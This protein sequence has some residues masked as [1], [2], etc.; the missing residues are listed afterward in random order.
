MAL[1]LSSSQSSTFEPF[2]KNRWVM[3]FTSIP[4]DIQGAP[5]TL[6]FVAHTA[7]RPSITFNQVEYQR[8]NERF[9]VAGK[10][11]WN[12]IPMTFFDFVKGP[13]N[14]PS[15]SEILWGWSNEVYSPITGAM[16]FKRDYAVSGTLA[17]LDPAGGVSQVWNLFYCWPANVDWGDLSADDDGIS[18]VSLTVRYDYAVKAS[19]L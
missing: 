19:E 17:L 15:A 16:G 7:V 9:Y 10:P 18:E 1:V 3:Q 2:R 13:D 4:G 6:A 8:L 5:E 12:E 11:A 14:K